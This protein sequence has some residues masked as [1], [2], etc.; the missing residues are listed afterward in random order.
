MKPFFIAGTLLFCGC[1]MAQQ[2]A[3]SCKTSPNV[4]GACF[5]V[6][7]RLFVVEG[8]PRI[9]IQFDG[10]WMLGVY[11]RQFRPD[12][13]D[14][15]PKSVDMLLSRDP[16]STAVDGAYVVCPFEKD[17]SGLIRMVCIESADHL[18]AHRQGENITRPSP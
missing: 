9:R 15:V 6:D 2:V 4:V 12:S 13:D 10:D 17:A 1:G 16:R 14:V 3:P 18:V 7:G 11:D 8:R 5:T